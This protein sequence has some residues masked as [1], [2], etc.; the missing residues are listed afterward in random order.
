VALLQRRQNLGQNIRR[1]GRD[2]SERQ[3]ASQQPPA[4]ARK[5]LKVAGSAQQVITPASNFDTN[6]RQ[7]C[8]TRSS[9]NQFNSQIALKI[10]N[11][12]R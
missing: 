4:M 6:F 1:Q 3:I 2:N 9:L 12:H 5:I 8:V 11:L 10:A 7:R